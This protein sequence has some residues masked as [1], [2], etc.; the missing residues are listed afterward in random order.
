MA[1]WLSQR[2]SEAN[3]D[4]D[5]ENVI[6]E[7]ALCKDGDKATSED[8]L[9]FAEVLYKCSLCTSLPCILT[10][11]RAFL[12]HMK[13][14][15]LVVQKAGYQCQHCSLHFQTYTD[16]QTHLSQ[17][18]PVHEQESS[19]TLDDSN[20][21]TNSQ[22]ST[23]SEN[24]PKST[25]CEEKRGEKDVEEHVMTDDQSEEN[26]STQSAAV[27]TNIR[28]NTCR[29]DTEV[30]SAVQTNTGQNTC[31]DET[32]VD[33]KPEIS[34][35][36]R[37]SS[38]TPQATLEYHSSPL[39]FQR[40]HVASCLSSPSPPPHPQ[41]VDLRR[42]PFGGGNIPEPFNGFP[43]FTPEFGRYTKLIREGGRI[44]YFC[45][46]CNVKCQ[47]KAA[48]QVHCNGVH[49]H[50]NVN[51]VG[52]NKARGSSPFSPRDASLRSPLKEVPVVTPQLTA[53]S[54]GEQSYIEKMT[55]LFQDQPDVFLN[56]SNGFGDVWGSPVNFSLK[57]RSGGKPD[58]GD[59]KSIEKDCVR[60]P[61]KGHTM[62]GHFCLENRNIPPHY[63]QGSSLK[64]E[65]EEHRMTNIRT[66]SG[67]ENTSMCESV[68]DEACDLSYPRSRKRPAPSTPCSDS[69]T[70]SEAESA[71]LARTSPMSSVRSADNG[72]CRDSA[73]TDSDVLRSDR[74]DHGDF[75]KHTTKKYSKMD[76][77]HHSDDSKPQISLS[78][79][80]PVATTVH[81][82]RDK[83]SSPDR[84][85]NQ[86]TA[87]SQQRETAENSSL[88]DDVSAIHTRQQHATESPS[89][90]T[91]N[92]PHPRQEQ[93]PVTDAPDSDP[94]N[95]ETDLAPQQKQ[96]VPTTSPENQS[97]A[98]CVGSQG[99]KGTQLS[100]LD[101]LA[102]RQLSLEGGAC[103]FP[104]SASDAWFHPEA[105]KD[106][107]YPPW[108][109]GGVTLHE[110]D[111]VTDNNKG[112]N[113][114][115]WKV[116]R[117]RDVLRGLIAASG[118]S[119]SVSR[120]M[121]LYRV[122]RVLDAPDVQHW[123]PACNRA[124]RDLFPHCLAQRKGKFKKTYFFGLSLVPLRDE[125]KGENHV[126]VDGTSFRPL[127]DMTQDLEQLLEHLPGLLYWSGQVER[128][129]TRDAV[130]HVLAERL[131][132]AEVFHWGMQCNKALRMLFPLVHMKRKGKYKTYPFFC[133]NANLS[134]TVHTTVY[135]GVDFTLDAQ[136]LLP[137][138]VTGREQ[139]PW[140]EL[141]GSVSN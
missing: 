106:L 91:E 125:T 27:Q 109:S 135:F 79:E 62:D 36:S 66:K 44:V 92:K 101:M 40:F 45:Q 55:K 23:D 84:H 138:M 78:H 132:E 50:N 20:S 137:P 6:N 24:S 105:G 4:R 57:D 11:E 117:I 22:Q 112:Q 54:R 82:E 2:E 52:R 60:Y 38:S 128:G 17:N 77:S 90:S 114:E 64:K 13:E 9:K 63:Q 80:E 96:T 61:E 53:V 31:K 5:K 119:S 39:H 28:Q 127:R 7:D 21:K 49:H 1:L 126:H 97:G 35:N 131:S 58:S 69:S 32:E 120:D 86:Q 14:H 46:V 115:G 48:F 68:R 83:A 75:V 95:S 3:L 25:S 140:Q 72:L 76:S 81:C 107:D 93:T 87:L 8:L 139:I 99:S 124:V 103:F 89:Q 123:G 98:E 67:S 51:M 59:P 47:V 71:C 41:Q 16:L 102:K 129:V 73:D 10:S 104:G 12:R 122:S 42:S 74:R 37:P 100:F 136:K 116:T 19:L 118:K 121:L 133:F 111:D 56:H 70:M 141:G 43:S 134:L 34:V 26:S 33:I 15:H 29:D 85:H 94:P 30:S 88:T 108:G 130:L 110:P 113:S 65:I 18:H